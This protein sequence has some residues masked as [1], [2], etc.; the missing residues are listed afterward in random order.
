MKWTE[1]NKARLRA[2]IDNGCSAN[3]VA[4][5]YGIS[6][7]AA[8]SAINRFCDR[9]R[10][11]AWPVELVAT[12]SRL[13]SENVSMEAMVTILGKSQTDITKKIKD[14]IL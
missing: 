6:L 11:E 1:T 5:R 12:L 7:S 2:M 4:T 3:D 8:K 10:K 13:V 9:T 14:L